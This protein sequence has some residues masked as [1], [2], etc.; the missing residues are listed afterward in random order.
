VIWMLYWRAS[1]SSLVGI[2]PIVSEYCQKLEEA[3]RVDRFW[4]YPQELATSSASPTSTWRRLIESDNDGPMLR[5]MFFWGLATSAFASATL[6]VVNATESFSATIQQQLEMLQS[7]PSSAKF[8]K[9][10]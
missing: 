5:A 1:S 6:D 10:D 9:D 2:S 8:R 4:A 7:D 3:R